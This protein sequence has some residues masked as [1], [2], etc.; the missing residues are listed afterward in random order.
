MLNLFS[1]FIGGGIGAVIRY[2]IGIFFAG[3]NVNFPAATFFVNILGSFIMGVL[4]VVF[5]SKQG[6]NPAVKFALTVGF[7]GGLTTFSTFS[8]ELF[9]MIKNAQYINAALYGVT[10][11]FVCVMSVMIGAY[12]AKLCI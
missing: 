3:I 11:V 5:L 1:V 4:Y 8:V 10:S 6:F 12:I 2:M 9:E 7:C